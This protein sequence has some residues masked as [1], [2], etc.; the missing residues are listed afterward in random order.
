MKNDVKGSRRAQKRCSP[1]CF[2]TVVAL[3]GRRCSGRVWSVTM[4][5]VIM[6]FLY[7]ESPLH[8]GPIEH[9]V[10]DDSL[11]ALQYVKSGRGGPSRWVI[12]IHLFAMFQPKSRAKP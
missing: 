6:L 12:R 11:I 3:P 5:L 8:T 1:C 9:L 10:G 4:S 2:T 7:I